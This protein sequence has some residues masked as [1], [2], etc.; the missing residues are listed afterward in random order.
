LG[1]ETPGKNELKKN[2]VA[3]QFIGPALPVFASQKNKFN[4]RGLANKLGG[5]NQRAEQLFE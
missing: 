1:H 3:A 2:F 5:H 4:L